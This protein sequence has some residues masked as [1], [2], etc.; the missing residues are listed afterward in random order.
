MSRVHAVNTL[1]TE[2]PT[3]H[4]PRPGILS[5]RNSLAPIQMRLPFDPQL[6]YSHTY[7]ISFKKNLRIQQSLSVPVLLRMLF[8]Y[9]KNS[10]PEFRLTLKQTAQPLFNFLGFW[11]ITPTR[12][13]DGYQRFD[14][15]CHDHLQGLKVYGP[16][17][18][19]TMKEARSFETSGTTHRRS[20]TCQKIG[21][22]DSPLW[23]PH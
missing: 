2:D 18:P 19:L 5:L 3:P 14:E 7:K 1:S 17:K 11:S 15:T 16:L 12:W 21:I 22:L 13:V 4:T 9:R 20:I 23:K 6:L 8:I 10:W